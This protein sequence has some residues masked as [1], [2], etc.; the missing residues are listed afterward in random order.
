MY[1]DVFGSLMDKNESFDDLEI[2]KKPEQTAEQE[3]IEEE[4]KEL[5]KIEEEFI[6]PLLD[7]LAELNDDGDPQQE[8]Q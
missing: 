8:D 5:E 4:P 7:R 6:D 2:Y 1:M 3:E